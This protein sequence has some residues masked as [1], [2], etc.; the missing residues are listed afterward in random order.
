MKLC[1][2]SVD[3]NQR[4]GVKTEG[5]IVDITALGFPAR[6]NDIIEGGEDILKRITDAMQSTALP[7]LCEESVKF[8]PVTEPMKVICA[9]LN[10]VD[11]AKE[12]GASIPDHPVLFNKFSDSLSAHREPV[13]LPAWLSHYDYEAELVVVIGKHVYNVDPKDAELSVFGYT[14]GNDLSA[15]KAQ[16]LSSQWLAGKAIPGFGPVG[17]YIVTADGFN[18]CGSNGVYC[19]V[20][21]VREQSGNT[22]DMI[23][24][25][26]DLLATAS[27]FFPLYPG[28]IIFT[29]TPHGVIAGKKP[30]DRVWL[31]PGDVVSI[32]IDGI[33]TLTTPLV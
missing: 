12:T 25:C 14:C 11:H 18:P 20:N 17:P 21:G 2:I 26:S 22:L 4:I 5:G 28:D 27:R 31:K 10:Y 15:R 7:Q 8:L 1:S 23:F 6:M 32:T 16:S 19:D 24:T 29:G 30:E 33:G 9:G 13:V 3:N